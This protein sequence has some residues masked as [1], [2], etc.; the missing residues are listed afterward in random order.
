MMILFD[1]GWLLVSPGPA[2]NITG[3]SN[4]SADLAGKRLQ[5][6]KETLPKASRVAM[7]WDP[8]SRPAMGYVRETEVA[9]VRWESSS[10]RWRCGIPRSWRMHSGLQARGVPRRLIVV[11]TGVLANDQRG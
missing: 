5:L 2:G 11:G 9:A 10:S 1:K 7:I 4:I 3:F 6:L 8:D